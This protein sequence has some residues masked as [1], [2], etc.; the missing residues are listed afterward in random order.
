[1][2]IPKIWENCP[3]VYSY[4]DEKNYPVPNPLPLGYERKIHKV[5]NPLF[6][7]GLLEFIQENQVSKPKC[8]C[9]PESHDEACPVC[10]PSSEDYYIYLNFPKL[11][12]INEE[13]FRLV[14]INEKVRPTDV[15]N[16][17]GIGIMSEEER[18]SKFGLPCDGVIYQGSTPLYRKEVKALTVREAARSLKGLDP[19]DAQ[20]LEGALSQT[21][22]ELKIAIK[23]LES[24]LEYVESKSGET[25]DFVGSSV[26]DILFNECKSIVSKA[27][28]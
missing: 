13:D 3:E 28:R 24:L 6:L 5:F 27:K 9:P 25:G 14:E 18:A 12:V 22:R 17:K 20:A 16:I 8:I 21:E 26:P 2:K 11:L 4:V 19:T 15:W 7:Q 1:M 10:I 23:Y